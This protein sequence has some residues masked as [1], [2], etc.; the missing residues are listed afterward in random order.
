[1]TS[2]SRW[3]R[4]PTK[5]VAC[6]SIDMRLR[7]TEVI[8]EQPAKPPHLVSRLAQQTHHPE[9]HRN[10]DGAHQKSHHDR[11][12]IQTFLSTVTSR[13]VVRP[14]F[15]GMR[16]LI[17]QHTGICCDQ[18]NSA[19]NVIALLLAGARWRCKTTGTAAQRSKHSPK[20]RVTLGVRRVAVDS[21]VG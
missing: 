1:M 16:W 5:W 3:R 6:I 7:V 12:G 2:A 9:Q 19:R 20:V 14:D 10:R 8:L 15:L 17:G 4:F 13:P 21:E 18:D 11:K